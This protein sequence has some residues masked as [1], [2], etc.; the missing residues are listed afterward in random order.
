[1]ITNTGT[2]RNSKDTSETINGNS[3]ITV[4]RA[5]YN[6]TMY[7][8]K[9]QA[10]SNIFT[11][12]L[13]VFNAVPKVVN[14][15][16]ALSIGGSIEPTYSDED[17]VRNVVKNLQL[18]E[19][20]TFMA[21]ELILGKSILIEIQS[22]NLNKDSDNTIIQQDEDF[23]YNMAYYSADE[24]E[25]ISV[26]QEILYAEVSGVTFKLND[27]GTEYDE[28]EITKVFIKDI[29]NGTARSYI[30]DSDGNK[31]DEI[32]YP[33][34][35][36]PLVEIVTTYDMKQLFYSVDRHNEF[37]SFIR[38][39]LYLAGEPIIAGI[40]LDKVQKQ[41]QDNM[42]KDRMQKQ[43]MMFTRSE[44]AKLQL[45]EITGSSARV[46]IEKQQGIVENII[47]DYPEYSISEVLSGSNVSEETTRIRLTE[48]LS[49][50]NELRG[51]IERG[52]NK[53]IG[54]VAYFEGKEIDEEYITLGDMVDSNTSE[55][56]DAVVTALNAGIISKKSAMNNI[57]ELFIGE[58]L[59][60][61]VERVRQEK[62]ENQQNQVITGDKSSDLV[63]NNKGEDDGQGS[64]NGNVEK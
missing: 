6:S 1:M 11:S 41:A 43:K 24:Y 61:E 34:G 10:M 26:G 15:A 18:E 51:N 37:E 17:W 56:I 54:I 33:D 30:T 25:I 48:I 9:T 59:E 49:R 44:T 13:P 12:V 64:I 53:L 36:L 42:A 58:N 50:I 45:L 31:T 29:E 19:E 8:D 16:S 55:K 22:T 7:E 27:E 23:P 40:G 63:V 5:Y 35:R 38:S 47:K 60:E 3:Y 62:E 14:I 39:I 20:K 2:T 4:S 52:F 32:E 28:V 21:R 46:M 57:K